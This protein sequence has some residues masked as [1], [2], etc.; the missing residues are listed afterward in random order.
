MMPYRTNSCVKQTDV[1]TERGAIAALSALSNPTRLCIY[2]MLTAAGPNGLRVGV[3]HERF[4][5]AKA[6][7]SFHLKTLAHSGL[8]KARRS[9][10]FIFY[11][12]EA[13]RMNEL[14][15]FLDGTRWKGSPMLG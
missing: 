2:R 9:S 10:T 11:I 6:T 15:E 1:V 3:I 8:V 4:D 13:E 14:I 12:A 7:L 5:M